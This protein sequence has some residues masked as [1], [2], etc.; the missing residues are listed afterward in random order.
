MIDTLI[1]IGDEIGS[2]PG[3]IAIAWASAKGVL[4][5]IGPRT[6]AQLDD[7]LASANLK[8]SDDHVRDRPQESS[9]RHR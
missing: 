8:L 1:A 9:Q 7:N 6:R 4:P 3:Q 2:N 5:V